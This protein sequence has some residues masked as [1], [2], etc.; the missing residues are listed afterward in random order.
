MMRIAIT[1]ASGHIGA[2]LTRELI[3][4]KHSLKLLIHEDTRGI[5]GLDYI[6][7]NGDLLDPRSLEELC[8]DVDVVFHL[9]ARISID[10][11]DRKLVYR[12]NVEG[13]RNV[14]KACQKNKVKRLIHFS[15]IHALDNT[16]RDI[17]MDETRPLVANN[18]I[19]YDQSKADSQK[20]V[21]EMARMNGLNVVILN[22]TAIVGPYDYKP[23]YLGRAVWRIYNGSL[24]MLVP[25]GY[26]FVDVRDVVQAAIQAIGNGR[27]GECYLLSG[28]Y[29]T[30]KELSVLIQEI[31]PH[32][33]PKRVAPTYVA[34]IGLPF[35]TAYSRLKKEHPLYTRESLE[36]LE[37]CNFDI[38]NEKARKELG[39]SPRPLKETLRD[40]FDWFGQHPE[41]R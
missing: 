26:N 33:T 2:V 4:N 7:V 32:Q 41:A 24:P 30:L 12:T 22:P 17:P 23:S 6:P 39:F 20:L 16:P 28:V 35:I 31:S 40:T 37:G 8:R 18:P 13:T 27:K 14:L 21:H 10:K 9:A 38:Q 3:K 25:G 19:I 29:M 11:K 34:K 1:G 15:S 36:I 5:Q